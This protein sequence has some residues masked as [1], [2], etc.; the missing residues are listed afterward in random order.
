MPPA[1]AVHKFCIIVQAILSVQEHVIFIP[2]SVRS[3]LKVQRGTIM[4]FI[5]LIGEAVP[6][7][8]AVPIEP[9]IPGI[10]IPVRSIIIALDMWRTPFLEKTGTGKSFTRVY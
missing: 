1:S 5:P 2:L 9:I 4:K 8:G 7:I 10:V 6:V 3:T